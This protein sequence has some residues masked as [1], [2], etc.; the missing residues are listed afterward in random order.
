[1]PMPSRPAARKLLLSLTAA[2]CGLAAVALAADLPFDWLDVRRRGADAIAELARAKTAAKPWQRVYKAQVPVGHPMAGLKIS[3][4]RAYVGHAQLNVRVVAGPPQLLGTGVVMDGAKSFIRVAGEKTKPLPAET[5]FRA[6]PVLEVPWIVFC[7]LE[8]GPQYTSAVEGEFDQ[9]AVLRLTPRYELGVT[10]RAGKV[11]VSKVS[12]Y[13]IAS[14][15]ND[16]KGLKLGE[17]DWLAF[18]GAGI[19]AEFQLLAAGNNPQPVR[20]VA[21]GPVTAPTKNAFT[22]GALK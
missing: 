3:V 10:A 20:F 19:P 11:S 4:A 21:E 5:L 16:G 9:V 12:G 6:Q 13:E 18:D 17:V 22:P 7:V 1:M 15:I 8:W 2:L 14:S